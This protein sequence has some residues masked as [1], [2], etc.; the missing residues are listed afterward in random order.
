[1]DFR[2]QDYFR[3]RFFNHDTLKCELL[4]V[5]LN[6]YS[7]LLTFRSLLLSFHIRLSN[8]TI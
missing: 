4:I 8:L 3:N 7:R 6:S 1:M 5:H 2:P